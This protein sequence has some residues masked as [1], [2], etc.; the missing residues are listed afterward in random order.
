MNESR[1]ALIVSIMTLIVNTW[2][3]I[4]GRPKRPG[5]KHRKK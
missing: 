1:L 3:A 2:M 5:G 4:Q